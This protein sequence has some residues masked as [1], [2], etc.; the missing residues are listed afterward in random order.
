[1]TEESCW[2]CTQCGRE[3]PYSSSDKYPR[4]WRFSLVHGL[5][6]RD[7]AKKYKI[8]KSDE[9]IEKETHIT[10]SWELL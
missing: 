1:M 3:G 8:K 4:G 6:C 2:C 10:E 9:D 5:V 7:C